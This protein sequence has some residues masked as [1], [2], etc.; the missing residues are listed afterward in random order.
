MIN[1]AF[2]VW[3]LTIIV[4]GSVVNIL[5]INVDNHKGSFWVL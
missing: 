2:R 3:T 5:V 1:N 4:N